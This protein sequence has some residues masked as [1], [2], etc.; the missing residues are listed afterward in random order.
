MGKNRNISNKS[1][2][3]FFDNQYLELMKYEITFKILLY[4]ILDKNCFS[5]EKLF[6]INW[7]QKCQSSLEKI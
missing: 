1:F 5:L 7:L 2:R 3:R 4:L 6:F